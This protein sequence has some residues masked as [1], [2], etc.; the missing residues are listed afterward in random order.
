MTQI[1]SQPKSE[2]SPTLATVQ[3]VEE[4]LRDVKSVVTI[5]QLKRSLPRK[6]NHITLKTILA[7]L[8]LS[9]KVE[10]T[11]H[12]VVWIFVPKEDLAAILQKGRAWT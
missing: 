1:L 4:A 6:V 11:P 3:M 2:H 10:F 12:G 8:Q 9:G 5:A 7:Y